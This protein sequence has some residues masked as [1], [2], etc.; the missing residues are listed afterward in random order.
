MNSSLYKKNL[1][2][3]MFTAKMAAFFFMWII[4]FNK[5]INIKCL[6]NNNI[7]AEIFKTA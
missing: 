7:L 2:P 1:Y 5:N 3:M 4:N 6:I